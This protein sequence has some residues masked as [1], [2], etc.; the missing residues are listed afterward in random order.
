MCPLKQSWLRW[1]GGEGWRFISLEA[2]CEKEFVEQH[3]LKD[4][5]WDQYPRSGQVGWWGNE[6]E[7]SRKRNGES[8]CN[9]GLSQYGELRA[10][11]TFRITG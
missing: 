5:P 10:R 3:P 6:A 2:N 4:S 1:G 8:N 11:K 7:V 9:H